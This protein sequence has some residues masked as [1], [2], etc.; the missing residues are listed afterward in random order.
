MNFV[1]LNLGILFQL[2]SSWW[3]KIVEEHKFGPNVIC[4]QHYHRSCV[5]YIISLHKSVEIK[6]R[7]LSGFNK[8]RS[9][10]DQN[11]ADFLDIFFG[12]FF[13]QWMGFF[14]HCWI[15]YSFPQAW[16]RVCKQSWCRARW[17]SSRR[18]QTLLAE[19]SWDPA[20]ASWPEIE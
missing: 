5:T 8:N 4:F 6:N 10:I 13:W 14:R 19:C 17:F 12:S 15:C 11:L 2:F 18:C 20:N 9:D 3:N 16:S 1:T 7:C